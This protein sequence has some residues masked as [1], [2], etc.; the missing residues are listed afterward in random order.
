AAPRGVPPAPPPQ[1]Q[2]RP[3][4]CQVTQTHQ[5]PVDPVKGPRPQ[6]VWPLG[7]CGLGVVQGPG[8]P[9]TWTGWVPRPQGD[10]ELAPGDLVARRGPRLVGGQ[11]GS[12]GE[13]GFTLG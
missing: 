10:E 3:L 12:N 2:P 7:V 1:I 4:H 6:G 8:A 9:R 11:E 5:P 13:P